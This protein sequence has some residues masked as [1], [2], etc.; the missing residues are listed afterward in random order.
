MQ[1]AFSSDRTGFP[2]VHIT[3]LGFDVHLLPITKS[4]FEAFARQDATLTGKYEEAI[5]LNPASP[6]TGADT[7]V[8]GRAL[9]PI[10]MTGVLPEEALQFAV[11]LDNNEPTSDYALPDVYEWRA[12]YDCLQYE[13]CEQYVV[14]VLENCPNTSAKHLV[15]Q[16]LRQQPQTLLELSLMR[17]GIIEWLHHE[18]SWA[19]LGSPR[20]KFYP[21]TFDP[22]HETVE[23]VDPAQRMR[24]FGFRLIRTF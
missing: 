5:V 7:K 2:L 3:E 22:L 20:P 23:P 4:Q 1:I 6:E 19:G 10:F 21:N 24:M 9:E 16:I 8:K 13:R 17:N 15:Q 12:V 18:T 14:D 11:W